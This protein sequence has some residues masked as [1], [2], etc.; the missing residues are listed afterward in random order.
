MWCTYLL[1]RDDFCSFYPFFPGFGY[2]FVV[3]N[4][5]KKT[6]YDVK[7]QGV[8][9]S[10]Y[11]V[12]RGRTATFSISASTGGF[13]FPFHF[14]LSV[15]STPLVSSEIRHSQIRR[16]DSDQK[17]RE[18]GKFVT[19]STYMLG[20]MHVCSALPLLWGCLCRCS[21]LWRE[22]RY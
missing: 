18:V 5:D 6:E 10:P 9:I 7:V 4:P 2:G 22:T 17:T 19:L 1:N 14:P 16:F 21:N 3:C 12:A 11:P 15:V 8:E 13:L 20:N